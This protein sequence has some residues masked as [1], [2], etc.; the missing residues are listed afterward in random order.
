MNNE[1]KG[2]DELPDS[3]AGVGD[4]DMAKA[5]PGSHGQGASDGALQTTERQRPITLRD[6]GER[7]RPKA[8]PCSGR[9]LSP[10]LRT[11]RWSVAFS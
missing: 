2:A 7:P 8:L 11:V 10:Y 3:A 1:D 5:D 9:L 6:M 4:S